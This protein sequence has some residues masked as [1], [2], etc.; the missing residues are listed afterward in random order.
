MSGGQLLPQDDSQP[1]DGAGKCP[2]DFPLHIIGEDL[3]S[4]PQQR[5]VGP[6]QGEGHGWEGEGAVPGDV[7][8]HSLRPAGIRHADVVVHQQL[9]H[10]GLLG[11]R[12]T[13]W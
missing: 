6:A 7:I 12:G 1:V 13:S 10:D 8:V 5:P 9:R 3:V 2:P 4:V 11:G